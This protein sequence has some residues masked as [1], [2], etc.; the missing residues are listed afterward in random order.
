[1]VDSTA[2]WP[3]ALTQRGGRSVTTRPAAAGYLYDALARRGRYRS[4]VN[5]ATMKASKTNAPRA[6]LPNNS[7]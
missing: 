5:A 7:A 1:M 4:I 3:V 2:I 6:R